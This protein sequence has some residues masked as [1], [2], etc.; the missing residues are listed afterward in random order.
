MNAT[1]DEYYCCFYGSCYHLTF[2]SMCIAETVVSKVNGNKGRK[3]QKIINQGG[4]TREPLSFSDSCRAIDQR[5][6]QFI[7]T[8]LTAT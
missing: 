5:H 6:K 2:W 1:L 7:H 4:N 3:R 8:E